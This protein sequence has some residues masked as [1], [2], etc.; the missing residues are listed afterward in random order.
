MCY[1]ATGRALSQDNRTCTDL[2]EC[3]EWGH[4]D[5]LCSNSDG[6]YTCQCAA[7]YTLM[8]R[9][10]CSASNAAN[11][12]LIFAHERAILR[13]TLHGQDSRIIANATGASGVAFHHERNLLFWSDIKTRN[14][15]SQ[16]LHEGGYGGTD[17]TLPGT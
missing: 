1:C 8:D 17:I 14:V 6:S 13:M 3:K 4:C 12:D 9:S 11:L 15:Q 16:P 10:R 5:Q 7:G 2:D